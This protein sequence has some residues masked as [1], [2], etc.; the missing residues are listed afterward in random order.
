MAEISAVISSLYTL[1]SAYPIPATPLCGSCY[2]RRLWPP[3]ARPSAWTFITDDPL[4]ERFDTPHCGVVEDI[5]QRTDRFRK[6]DYQCFLISCCRFHN[7]NSLIIRISCKVPLRRWRSPPTYR[8]RRPRKLRCL[9]SWPRNVCWLSCGRTASDRCPFPCRALWSDGWRRSCCGR[10][11]C[12]PHPP[13]PWNRGFPS[14]L[15]IVC[16]RSAVISLLLSSF[17]LFIR[18]TL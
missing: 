12:E 15:R 14:W 8:N 10:G 4:F 11:S 16:R 13:S 6:N 3:S 1:L 7:F 5:I 18:F 2:T 9:S 17:R